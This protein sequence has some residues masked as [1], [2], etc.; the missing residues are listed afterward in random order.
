VNTFLAEPYSKTWLN[1][2]F[3]YLKRASQRG[4]STGHGK[5]LRRRE[6]DL[7]QVLLVGDSRLDI[8]GRA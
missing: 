5:G 4:S 2:N 8:K 7:G 1:F 3:K 6:A